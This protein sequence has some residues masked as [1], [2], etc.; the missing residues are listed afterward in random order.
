[1]SLASLVAQKGP[2]TEPQA[3][4]LF[5]DLT[6]WLEAH[7]PTTIPLSPVAV[8]EVGGHWGVDPGAVRQDLDYM[9]PELSFGGIPSVASTLYSA[10]GVMWFALTG[11]P[12]FAGSVRPPM[13]AHLSE[14]VPIYHGGALEAQVNAIVRACMAKD[15]EA[16]PGDYPAAIALA[17][18]VMADSGLD[19]RHASVGAGAA[20]GDVVG[21]AAWN[22]SQ[23]VSANTSA[24]PSGGHVDGGDAGVG[25]AGPEQ[26]VLDPGDGTVR[27]TGLAPAARVVEFSQWAE[28]SGSPELGVPAVRS[29]Y[30]VLGEPVEDA[31]VAGPGGEL[32]PASDAITP[33]NAIAPTGPTMGFDTPTASPDLILG[34]NPDEASSLMPG[35]VRDGHTDA[36]IGQPGVSGIPAVQ[37][38]PDQVRGR[39]NTDWG[40][41]S[42]SLDSSPQEEQ[43]LSYEPPPPPR[44]FSLPGGRRQIEVP[45]IDP[46]AAKRAARAAQDARKRKGKR[47]GAEPAI[48]IPSGPVYPVAAPPAPAMAPTPP[49]AHLQQGLHAV[50]PAPV[51]AYT[52]GSAPGQG[53]APRGLTADANRERRK[54][55]KR[56]ALIVLGSCLVVLLALVVIVP[57]M[58]GVVGAVITP[59]PSPTPIIPIQSPDVEPTISETHVPEETPEPS[60]SEMPVEFDP[61]QITVTCSEVAQLGTYLKENDWLDGDMNQLPIGGFTVK[62][63]KPCGAVLKKGT[64]A[65]L[66]H[67]E[68]IS[69]QLRSYDMATGE[70]LLNGMRSFDLVLDGTVHENYDNEFAAV[71]KGQRHGAT[72]LVAMTR[73]TTANKGDKM[74][75]VVEIE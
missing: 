23:D 17:R 4:A 27:P 46:E 9:A 52:Q 31:A 67:A 48:V 22:P 25:D 44:A 74:L 15:K 73:G 33:E 7:S 18:S 58:P 36:G 61:T 57:N 54:R 49:Q 26:L 50:A 39:G 24:V 16:R 41:E 3:L 63:G 14:R 34:A 65:K 75:L 64:G 51:T 30:A 56:P 53:P 43:P 69:Y 45:N 70:I 12:P 66:V 71:L 55:S 38:A 21:D 32:S 10:A 35:S 29:R 40:R 5:A 37:P 8:I 11:A 62:K 6:Q 42:G 60:A 47:R 13:I 20:V 68:T 1:L 2:L 72:V 59:S 28:E 19:W